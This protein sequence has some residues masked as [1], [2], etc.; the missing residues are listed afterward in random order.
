VE[1]KSAISEVTKETN[2]KTRRQFIKAG[3][4]TLGLMG[5]LLMPFISGFRWAWGKT[6]KITLPKGT[7]KETLIQKNPADLD[8]RNLEPTPLDEFGTMGLTDHKED[9]NTWRLTVDGCVENPLDMSYEQLIS[10]PVIERDVLLICPGVFANHGRWKGISIKE[11]LRKAQLR[12]DPTH[13]TFRGPK[14]PYENVQ[15]YPIADVH[16]DKVFLAY[17]VNGRRL[18]EKHGFPLRV[19]AEGYYGY[20]WI[21]YVHKLTVEKIESQSEV[22]GKD[23]PNS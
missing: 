13:V 15:T 2:M 4:K 12:T 19:V 10:L 20:D 23:L 18:P 17:Q 1:G 8:T 22:D 7:K 11:L 3:F 16:S 5:I 6:G 14:P 21:K 9:L